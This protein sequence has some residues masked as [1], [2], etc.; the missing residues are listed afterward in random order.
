MPNN[1][2]R[3]ISPIFLFFV[4]FLLP[5]FFTKGFITTETFFVG[6]ELGITFGIIY[7]VLIELIKIRIKN[8]EKW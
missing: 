2:I 3:I 6:I 5:E 8:R 4:G 1:I 7:N